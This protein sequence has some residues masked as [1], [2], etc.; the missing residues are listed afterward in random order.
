PRH[1]PPP[2]LFPSTTLFRSHS[3]G[4]RRRLRLRPPA[5]VM[6]KLYLR[7]YLAVLVSLAAFAL[8]SGFLWRQLG[9]AGPAGRALDVASTLAQRS[10]EHTSELQSRFDLVCR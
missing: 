1:P 6:R 7:V 8:A 3:D 9:D 4:A 5:G 10:E 2:P